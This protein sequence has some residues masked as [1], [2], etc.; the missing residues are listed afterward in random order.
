MFFK[1]ILN[2]SFRV[3]I[4]EIVCMEHE[5]LFFSSVSHREPDYRSIS[6]TINGKA[7]LMQIAQQNGTGGPRPPYN[8]GVKKNLLWR[9]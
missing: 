4:I 9:H 5:Y 3:L 2:E 8:V 7:V 1:L 6:D